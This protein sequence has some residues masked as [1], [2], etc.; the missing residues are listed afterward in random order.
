MIGL[1]PSN[2]ATNDTAVCAS[3]AATEG[4][5]GAS[6]TRFGTTIADATDAGPEP[7]AFVAAAVHVYDFPF[8]R[9]P[10]TRGE[11][12]P[13]L[14][15]G[16]PPSDDVQVAAYPVIALPPSPGTVKVTV[17]CAFPAPTVGFAGADG[18][19]LGTTAVDAGEGAPVPLAFVAVTV[20]AYDFPFV[21][22]FTMIGEP[23]PDA[24]PVAPPFDDVHVTA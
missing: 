6:G 9:P 21:S 18:T 1:P 20:H 3:P 23:A 10:T 2:G 15:P 5:A 24:D 12:A 14:L 4:W 19:V 13:V 17:T 16:A 11:A 22:A 8:V 7:F